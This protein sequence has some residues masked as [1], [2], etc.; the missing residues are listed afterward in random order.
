[1]SRPRDI[2]GLSRRNLMEGCATM[3][4][5]T[6]ALSL[7]CIVTLA[8]IAGC[9]GGSSAPN[10]PAPSPPSPLNSSNLNLIFV[11]SE[12][13]AHHAVGDINPKTANLTNRGLQRTLRV[14]SFLQ[15]N[16]LGNQNVTEIFALEPMTHLQT[17]N[18]Y[19]DMV[20]LE[21]VQ[22]FAMLNQV[23]LSSDQY[24]G[25]PLAGHS[26][27][28][29]ASY[30]NV[31]LPVG[32]VPPQQFC[33]NCQGLDF[34]DQDGDNEGLLTRIV[35]RA[36][37]GFYVFSAP[38]E[39][40]SALM[41]NINQNKGYNLTL[42]TGYVGPNYIYAIAITPSGSASLVTYNSNVNPPA[43]YPVLSP[44]P[45]SAPCNA[46]KP[47]SITVTG[48]QGGAVIP[49]GTNVNET[50]YIIR[51][52]DAHPTA[53][54]DDNNYVG[55]GQWRALD[56]PNALL[57]KVVKVDQV[58]SNDPSQFGPGSVN[59][60]GVSTWSSVAPPLTAAAYAIANNL[61]YN[62]VTGFDLSDSQIDQETSTFFFHGGQFSNQTV[63]LAWSYQFIQPTINKLL[64]AYHGDNQPAPA[65][66]PND[67]DTI[68]TVKLDAHGNVTVNNGMCEGIKSLPPTA[69]PPQF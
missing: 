29:N 23:T 51:H 8:V 47:F 46:Q 64:N 17:A 67:Y 35:K 63:L 1:M 18:N 40:V 7:F 37:P 45:A 5:Q 69:G 52:A 26:F 50:L 14:A 24:G 6:I 20:G 43:T 19:P 56:L 39:T 60:T 57:G 28:I 61:P 42:P 38:W 41:A 21:T 2:S 54:W 11:A 3:R 30:A 55:A 48:G 44:P 13:L 32:V 68:W 22:Q 53:Y 25:S 59:A 49:A 34:R 62:L 65:W 10:P 58:Y 12:D 36:A 33:T 15:Q 66:P 27:P 31:P 9:G 16:V 4:R